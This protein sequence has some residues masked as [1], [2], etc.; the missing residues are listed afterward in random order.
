MR[1]KRVGTGIL[2]T[3]KGLFAIITVRTVTLCLQKGSVFMTQEQYLKNLTTPKGKIDVVLDTDAY[4][5]IDDQFAISYMLKFKHKFN[6]KGICAAPFLNGKSTSAEDGMEKSYNE[7]LK[8]L[9]L[10][11]EQILKNSVYKG[12]GHYLTD[13]FTPAESQAADYMATLAKEYSAESPLYIVAIGAITNVAS[14]ILKNPQMCET[15]V[16]VWLGGHSVDTSCGA[17]E[18]NMKQDIA[19][20]RVVFGCRI[21]LVQLPCVGVVD[22]V[23]T[24]GPELTYWLKGK[25]ALSDYLAQNTI[26]EA[27]SYACGKP[28]SRV[29][30]DITAVAWLMN[31]DNKFMCDRLI[32]SPIPEY[33]YHYAFDG[34]RH[35]IRYVYRI[36]RDALFED[37]FKVLTQE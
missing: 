27:E 13:E 20:A 15:C 24:T 36:D 17:S 37:M 5:E 26:D 18:F 34:N 7:I 32:Q 4:N 6:I 25:N 16:V 12:S 29:I 1:S 23:S 2:L 30:W 10:A 35:F 31:E 33:D 9:D 22:R 14:A 11:D 21:P 19:A 3:A 28:W 8:L